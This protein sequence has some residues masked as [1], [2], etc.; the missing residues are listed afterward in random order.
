MTVLPVL[1]LLVVSVLYPLVSTQ[2]YRLPAA[3]E[4][5]TDHFIPDRFRQTGICAQSGAAGSN[6]G[7]GL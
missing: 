4:R 1:G 2:A 7:P 5:G 6:P 3:S